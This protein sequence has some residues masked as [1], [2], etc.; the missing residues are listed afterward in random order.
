MGRWCRYGMIHRVLAAGGMFVLAGCA[1]ATFTI[2]GVPPASLNT[3]AVPTAELEPPSIR[4][5]LEEQQTI[6]IYQ[7]IIRRMF[8][9]DDTYGG[10][11][12]KP[13]LF[14]D[15][16]TND[17]ATYTQDC[18]TNSIVLPE[19]VQQGI[20]YALNELPTWIV[21]IRHFGDVVRDPDHGCVQNRGVIITLSNIR[22]EDTD[23]AL[24]GGSLFRC[25]LEAGGFEYVVE[26]NGGFWNIASSRMRW[27]G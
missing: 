17:C 27:I 10:D 25:D 15:R 19:T 24:V 13:I 4:S 23:V 2:A 20:R 11:L 21:W 3:P 16:S 8:T 14:I 7:A 5:A 18:E 9:R 12:Y 6:A 22:Y 26:N 1:A